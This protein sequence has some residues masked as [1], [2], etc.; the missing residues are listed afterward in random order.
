MKGRWKAKETLCETALKDWVGEGWW[1][2]IIN[3]TTQQSLQGELVK[4]LSVAQ[5]L[6]CLWRKFTDVLSGY[7]WQCFNFRNDLLGWEHVQPRPQKMMK[8][9]KRQ[10]GCTAHFYS[11]YGILCPLARCILSHSALAVTH[12]EQLHTA[13]LIYALF[14]C[15]SYMQ[16]A[17]T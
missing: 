5:V 8:T 12:E 3:V 17:C 9:L 14:T 10:V 15:A 11:D 4:I 1:Y 13:R 16:F 7:L 6:W 2:Y